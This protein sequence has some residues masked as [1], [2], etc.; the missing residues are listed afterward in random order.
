MKYR[1]LANEE[2][3][4]LGFGCMRLPKNEDGTINETEAIAQIRYGIDQGITY[5][6]TA[7][8]YHDGMSEQLVAKALKDG[9]REK[10]QL[11][12]KLPSW[13]IKSRE[14]MDTYLDKQ[15]ERLETEQIDFYLLHALDKERWENYK[16]NGVFDFIEKAKASG[17]I[18]HIG[19]SFH[20]TLDVF[21]QIIDE[22]DSWEFCQI[23]LNYLDE[24]Y[25]AGLAGLQYAKDRNIGVIIMEPL[26]GGSL[27]ANIAPE[28]MDL[29]ASIDKDRSPASF[30]LRYLY[31]YDNVKVILSGMNSIE[32]LDDN[33][34]TA[35][36]MEPGCLDGAEMAMIKKVKAVF[37]S[38]MQVSCTACQYCMPC[39]VGVDIPRNFS[40]YNRAFMFGDPEGVKESYLASVKPE[41]RASKCIKCGKC[42]P[43]CPQH[44][45]IRDQLA[46]VAEFFEGE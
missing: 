29:F 2:V 24:D 23:Q 20:D 46:K 33:I 30:A 38:K 22:Y 28:I 44:I 19:F 13:L 7:W 35:S 21:K 4:I 41:Q 32:Q 15:L 12:T 5:I 14:D 9:Y 45:A 1:Q 16:T 18:K 36:E 39:P 34:A 3:S 27:A 11:A 10:V 8:P 6:D 25:Q 31:N 26:R 43:Q 42:E 40:Y 17:K 37:E